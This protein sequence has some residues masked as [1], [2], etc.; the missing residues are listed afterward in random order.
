MLSNAERAQI[1]HSA[2]NVS[3]ASEPKVYLERALFTL[4]LVSVSPGC[5]ESDALCG[6]R[7]FIASLW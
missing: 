1:T 5:V 4:F 6:S 3:S 2:V 7:T